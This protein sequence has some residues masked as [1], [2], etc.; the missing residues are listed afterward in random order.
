MQQENLIHDMYMRQL[1]SGLTYQKGGNVCSSVVT[2]GKGEYQNFLKANK[3]QGLSKLGLQCK[4]YEDNPNKK[5][6][7]K[8]KKII[9]D[10][11]DP[12]LIKSKRKVAVAKQSNGLANYANFARNLRA[13]NPNMKLNAKDVACEWHKLNGTPPKSFKYCKANKKQYDANQ[14]VP[15]SNEKPKR[16]RKANK[17]LLLEYQPQEQYQMVPYNIAG[18]A[19]KTVN[20]I[21]YNIPNIPHNPLI[22]YV[23][24]FRPSNLEELPQPEVRGFPQNEYP[25]ALLQQP[26]RSNPNGALGA[27]ELFEL[28]RSDENLYNQVVSTSKTNFRNIVKSKNTYL[29]NN[30]IDCIYHKLTGKPV[31]GKLYYHCAKYNLL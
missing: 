28:I 30:D 25:I 16:G 6:P 29:S 8:F 4:Y 9:L 1:M 24:P 5:K 18:P 7:K 12:Q 26:A 13:N 10:C 22:N 11:N 19:I 15:Y 20:R 21:P 17:P 27:A 31:K 2:G 3:Q 14:M 23:M